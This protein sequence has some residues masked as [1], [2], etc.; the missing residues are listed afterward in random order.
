MN[1]RKFIITK[2]KIHRLRKKMTPEELEEYYKTVRKSAH[3]HKSKQ[4][5]RR[6]KKYKTDY[7]GEY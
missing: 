3:I 2:E 7:E 5:Y 1:K 4:D 6:K